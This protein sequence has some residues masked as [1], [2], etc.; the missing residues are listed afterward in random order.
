MGA[1]TEPGSKRDEEYRS[2]AHPTPSIDHTARPR[3]SRA[4]AATE[5][6]TGNEPDRIESALTADATSSRCRAVTTT[7]TIAYCAWY[8]GEKSVDA[9]QHWVGF[10]TTAQTAE[11]VAQG[12]AAW[13]QEAREIDSDWEDLDLSSLA[14]A[15][16]PI[17]DVNATLLHVSHKHGTYRVDWRFSIDLEISPVAIDG[18]DE[19]DDLI[20]TALS[21]MPLEPPPLP[22]WAGVG[23]LPLSELERFDW[24]M[25]P[26][27][28]S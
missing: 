2:Q 5:T 10:E 8:E 1:S 24:D 22:A 25:F 12:L 16:K 3:H 21:L 9:M 28:R 27:G 7:W 14:S 13:V 20:G 26:A 18:L 17:R 23:P 19:P 4:S 11:R 6:Q 15:I